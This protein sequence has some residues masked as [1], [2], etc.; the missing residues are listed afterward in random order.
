MFTVSKIAWKEIARESPHEM[1]EH[2]ILYSKIEKKKV[3]QDKVL[4]D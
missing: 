4:V 1:K 3:A 2:I